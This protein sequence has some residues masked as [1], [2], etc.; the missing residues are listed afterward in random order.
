M[1]QAL[2]YY[3][4]AI[5]LDPQ[6]SVILYNIGILFNIRAEYCEAVKTLEMA[7][8]LDAEN[9]HAYLALGDAFER[10]GELAKARQVFLSLQNITSNIHGLSQKI[11]YLD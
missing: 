10:Q 6:N 2:Y 9:V 8:N 4:R 5:D 7:I 3:K 11:Q 1:D